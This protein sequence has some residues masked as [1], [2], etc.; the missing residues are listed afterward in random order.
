MAKRDPKIW[1]KQRSTRRARE[2][3]RL[4]ALRLAQKLK[5]NAQSDG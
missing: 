4:V 3:L 1:E 2:E 5:E